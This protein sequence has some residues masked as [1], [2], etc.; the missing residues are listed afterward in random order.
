VP[1]TADATI[2]AEIVR[3]ALV[4]AAE[5]ASIVVVR[6]SHSTNI[7]EGADAA[8]A[9]LDATGRLVAQSAATSV[10][11]SA[12]LR[13]G[14]QSLLEQ[15]HVTAMRPGDVYALN[16]PYMGG[17]HA[18][19]IMVLTP[20]FADGAVRWFGGTLIHV[21]DMGGTTA[22][23]L[24]A[25]AAD[26]F[27]EGVLL[28]PVHLY[29]EGERNAD[30]FAIIERNSRAPSKVIGDVQALVAGTHVVR[31][32]MEELVERYGADELARQVDAYIDYA[33]RRFHEE[34]AHIPAGTYRGSF[35]IDS[36]GVTPGRDLD[37]A[38]SVTVAPE[39]VV[40]DFTGTS[41]QSAGPINASFSQTLSGVVYAIRCFI[42][43]SIP[44]N[45]GCFGSIRAVLPE[46]SLVNPRPPAAC[47][48]RVVTVAAAV[49]A[50]LE[51]LSHAMPDHAVAA[52][53]LIHVYTM[54]GS[55]PGGAPW[56]TLGY[57]FGGIGARAGCDGP[58]ATGAY[59][60]GGR[61]VIPQ[62]EPLEAQLPFVAERCVLVPDS[63][64]PGT[65]RG[66]LGVEVALR[67]TAPA[68]LTVRGDRI[69]LPPPGVQGGEPGRAGF[70][71]VE[72]ADG[73]REDLA[74]RQQHVALAPGDV[75]VLRTSGGGGLG[76]PAARPADAVRDDIAEGRVTPEGAERDY[77][78][79]A[80]SGGDDRA[81]AE[82][83]RRP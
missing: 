73:H 2:T 69:L 20:V 76:P 39:E 75:F 72:R 78:L 48:G 37:V 10:M 14:L 82:E 29:R 30:V 63:G 71:A 31:R 47:G 44:M 66:G 57:E 55:R 3:N 36:D 52:S 79:S 6:S 41:P 19:D 49:E 59:F 54:S 9:L 13:C 68:E 53:A 45:E 42:D 27:A 65:W 60:L 33:A 77:G 32:R 23:G 12:S 81:R 35:T 8:A 61:S 64:G 21:A 25:L 51:A 22:G 40:I 24:G 38:V 83:A 26:T 58:D 11:H 18:N 80:R 67:M 7:Q 43:P 56:L 50:I 5:E 15:V 17:I 28:P 70:F 4:V 46:G 74:A 16:D 1:P 62:L 34:L